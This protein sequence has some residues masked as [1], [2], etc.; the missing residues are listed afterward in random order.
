MPYVSTR[1]FTTLS[2][3]RW[4]KPLLYSASPTLSECPSITAV[5]VGYCFMKSPTLAISSRYWGLISALSTSNS[6]CSVMQYLKCSGV[7][8]AAGIG[9][10]GSSTTGGGSTGGAA[11]T[12]W[13]GQRALA[14]AVASFASAIPSA[15]K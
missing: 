8:S 2:A 3:R 14:L 15:V 11:C 10:S 6:V 7:G 12:T 13:A 4:D 1:W 9:G 5:V